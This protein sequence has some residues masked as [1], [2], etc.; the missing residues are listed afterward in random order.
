M[1]SSANLQPEITESLVSEIT[2]NLEIQ[3]EVSASQ[4][5]VELLAN[6]GADRDCQ[7]AGFF[8]GFGQ[9]EDSQHDLLLKVYG[10]EIVNIY[11]G[12]NKIKLL[13]QQSIVPGTRQD[14]VQLEER[15]RKLLITMIDDVR[16]VLIAIVGHLQLLRNAKRSDD[17]KKEHAQLARDMYAPL[18]N[19]LGLSQLKWEIEDYSFRYLNPNAYK[20]LAVALEERRVDREQHIETCIDE[21]AEALTKLGIDATIQGRA[22]HIF[23]IWKKMHSKGLDFSQLWDIRAIRVLVNSVEDCYQVLSYVHGSW[24]AFKSEFVDYIATPKAN[25]YQSIHTVIEGPMGKTL[26]IQIRTVDMHTDSELGTAAHWRYKAQ[27]N[28]ESDIDNKVVWLRQL[29]DWKNQLV[30]D[31]QSQERKRYSPAI[32][33]RV[34]E[35]RVFVFTPKG[36]VMDLPSGSTPIDFAYAVHT[37]VGNRTRGA[38]INGKMVPLSYVLQN[39]DH[40]QIQTLKSGGPSLDWLNK[41]PVYVV[42]NRAKSRISHWFKHQEYDTHVSEGRL[43]LDREMEKQRLDD[44]SYEKINQH[45]HFRKVDDLFAAIGSQDYK[46]SKALSPFRKKTDFQDDQRVI[47]KTPSPQH[48]DSQPGGF[49]VEGVG[50]LMTHP[51]QC[52]SPVPGDE[53]IGYITLGKG[54]S[55]HRQSCI[56]IKKRDDKQKNRLIQV[57]WSGEKPDR[58]TVE[59]FVVGYQRAGLL[60]DLTE[61]LKSVNAEI[62]K[63]NMETDDEQIARI[64]LRLEVPGQV[65]T[66]QLIQRLRTI[67]NIFEVKRR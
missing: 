36:T 30:S 66:D 29:L 5:I 27:V 3:G 1:V 22:K 65:G 39:G 31:N 50:N 51:A 14:V 63:A 20:T 54:V 21:F 18:A 62:I 17:A 55:I 56:N 26:E 2:A 19:M 52:C 44:L 16:V 48:H 28:S 33:N 57:D 9:L 58:Y 25:G 34:V 53:I 15:L 61:S 42:T 37:E 13:A 49:T 46:V 40:V 45:T 47:R 7:I 43:M 6:L 4:Q 67:Q 8:H 11:L 64:S 35:T 32:A 41:S 23:S 12:A 24:Q 10:D 60:H 38:L 59:I